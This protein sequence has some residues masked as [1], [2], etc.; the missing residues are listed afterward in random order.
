MPDGL[1]ICHDVR[2]VTPQVF[3]NLSLLFSSLVLVIGVLLFPSGLAL[4]L[5]FTALSLILFNKE[6]P[7]TRHTAGLLSAA[8]AFTMA[9][10]RFPAMAPI[11]AVCL[12]L[13]GLA[14]VLLDGS[15]GTR[16]LS[17][18][19]LGV[20]LVLAA[21]GFVAHLYGTDLHRVRA[22]NPMSMPEALAFVLAGAAIFLV[23]PN[24]GLQSLLLRETDGAVM[25]RRM[26]PTA[27]VALVLLGWLRIHGQRAGLYENG[28]GTVVFVISV[29]VIFVSRIWWTALSIDRK[30]QDR[31][32]AEDELRKREQGLSFMAESMPQKI[33]TATPSGSIEY[34]NHQWMEFTG[35]SFERLQEWGWLQ[36]IHPDDVQETIHRWKQSIETGKDFQMEHRFFRRDGSHRWHLSRARAMHDAEGNVIKWIGSNTDIHDQKLVQQE[37]LRAKERA[38]HANL[39]KD[40]FLAVISHELRTP[41]TSILGWALVLQDGKLDERGKA[42]AINAIDRNAKAQARL[43][44]DLLDVARMVTGKLALKTSE[45][46]ISKVL[47]ASIASVMPAADAKQIA[48]QKTIEDSL[49]TIA[50]D[51]LRLEQIFGNLLSNAV[52]FSLQGSKIEVRAFQVAPD[53]RVVVKD[54]G[55][56]IDPAF[57]PYVFDRF[58][59]ADSTTTRQ[60]GGLG[61]G[62]TIVRYLVEAH[63]GTVTVASAGTGQGTTFAVT[64]PANS[65]PVHHEPFSYPAAVLE[66]EKGLA[67]L[68]VLTVEDDTDARELVQ[69]I[70]ASAGASVIAVPSADEALGEL[71]LGVPDV[72]VADIGMSGKDG[73]QL[74]REIRLRDESHGGNVPAIALTAYA[75]NEDRAQALKAGFQ[76]YLPKP[77]DPTGLVLAVQR[78]AALSHKV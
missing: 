39:S 74:V 3:R 71:D 17:G 57:L 13:A 28:F 6:E 12:A 42:A 56:G 21:I 50:A 11:S 64:L 68:R 70:L 53:I 45:V 31:Q 63:G 19:L 46:D 65:I 44:E 27:V 35:A 1:K 4:G 59:Q 23:R 40:E 32:V 41:L 22:Y 16:R 37:L 30:D 36:Y 14:L 2:P 15:K 43:I 52:K 25:A 18:I 26:L 49:P 67:G 76:M 72:I 20:F 66:N 60:H 7:G 62:L 73:Y 8:L 34:L 33:F 5:M 54:T 75:R 38:D 55:R 78:V 48:I 24:H 51:P 61:L 10:I 77:V 58:R 69:T 9:V 29:S 47:Q